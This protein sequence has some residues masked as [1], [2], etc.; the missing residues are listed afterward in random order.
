MKY[1]LGLLEKE[2]WNNRSYKWM[3]RRGWYRPGFPPD[4][5]EE[6]AVWLALPG[7]H[8][9]YHQKLLGIDSTEL[10]KARRLLPGYD[11]LTT[12]IGEAF[13]TCTREDA[14]RIVQLRPGVY[15]AP[16]PL[17]SQLAMLDDLKRGMSQRRVAADF[18]CSAK[19]VWTLLNKGVQSMKNLPDDFRLLASMSQ[20]AA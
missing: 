10:A 3:R 14:I 6:I 4:V 1:S 19:F 7:I 16:I 9:R 15:S 12:Q 11:Q 18:G 13:L 8:N 2:P 17:I 5:L 20:I